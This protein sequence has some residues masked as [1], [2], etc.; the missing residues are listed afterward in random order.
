VICPQGSAPLSLFPQVQESA[1]DIH[2]KLHYKKG[3]DH[4]SQSESKRIHWS[5]TQ[6]LR[7]DVVT[8]AEPFMMNNG[9]EDITVQFEL[10][11]IADHSCR[12]S[13]HAIQQL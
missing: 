7:K 4:I 11:K 6:Q 10:N 2:P 12:V 5:I 1:T 3:S 9:K 8:L 13:F